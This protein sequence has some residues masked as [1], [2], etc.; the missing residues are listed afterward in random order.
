MGMRIDDAGHQKHAFGIDLLGAGRGF[1]LRGDL[2]DFLALDSDIGRHAAIFVDDQAVM[3]DQFASRLCLRRAGL[4]HQ[5]N[6]EAK[7]GGGGHA[8]GPRR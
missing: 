7:G 6:R 2:H 4:Q 8:A 3:N 5:H 1:D